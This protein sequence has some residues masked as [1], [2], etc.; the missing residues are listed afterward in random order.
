[1]GSLLDRVLAMDNLREAWNEVAENRGMAGVD[2]VS[3]KR[4]RRRW[5]E[6]L[7]NLA[8]DVRANRYKPAKLRVV[9]IPKK[10]R[11][12]YRT[13]RVPTVTDRVL[14]RAVLQVLYTIYEPRFLNC[15]FGYRPDRSLR[16]AVQCIIT[17]RD[18][19]LR[20]VLDADI[21]D[22]FDEVDQELLMAWVGEQVHDTVVLRLIR[23]WLERA[24]P[25]PKVPKGLAMGSP[26]SPLLA[27][28]VLH[29]LDLGLVAEGW[30][31]VRYADDFVVLTPDRA[32]A[33]L[34]YEHT[35]WI[36]EALHLRFEPA[37]TSITSFD[38]GFEFLGVWFEEDA[39]TYPWARKQITV[40]GGRA[41]ALF[42]QYGP[43]Y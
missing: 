18:R 13:L 19:G 16:D 21:D 37:K 27:N 9:R 1:M 28:V 40:K 26:L 33:E 25:R 6:R 5:E 4:W 43:D 35:G 8:A 30:S 15:S 7:V 36:L 38:E 14:Q 29:P 42:S 10:R 31:P 32:A 17:L 11:D 39:Y 20:W 24:R 34:A 22:F 3:I 12:Q 23:L 2:R 41:D